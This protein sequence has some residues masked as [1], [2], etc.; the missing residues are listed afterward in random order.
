MRAEFPQGESTADVSYSERLV[1]IS[2]P[3]VKRFEA[4]APPPSVA[5]AY[6]KYVRAQQRVHAY[7]VEALEAAK[8]E[9]TT[10]YLRAREKRD[11]EQPERHALAQEIG[12]KVCSASPE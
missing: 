3:A 2:T 4:L 6:E 8:R 11:E 5:G 1:G 9:D 12:F 10:A 7:D